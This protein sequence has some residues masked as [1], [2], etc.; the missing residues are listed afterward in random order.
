[1]VSIRNNPLMAYPNETIYGRIHNTLIRLLYP[2]ADKVIVVSKKIRDILSNQYNIPREKIEVIYNPHNIQ[3]YLKLSEEPIEDEYREIFKDS[4]VFIN[5]GRLMEP[6]GQW[7]LIRAF[8]KVVEAHSNAKLIILG[9]GKLRKGLEDLIRKLN[10]GNKVF[11]IGVHKNPFKFL[12]N[13]QCYVHSSLWEGLP[14]TLIEALTLNLPIISTDCETGPRE[15]LT[16]ELDID[17]KIDYPYF[18]KYGIL[19]KPFPRKYIFK[20]LEEKPLIEQE[21][22]LAELMI[23]MIENEELR[24][25]YSNGLERAR[26]FD[27]EK[28]I[29]KWEEVIR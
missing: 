3:N 14:N 11:L 22:Q 13:S 15:I 20:D 4:F 21:K 25:R 28:I 29:R 24:K 19:I 12:K 16:P 6:K 1:M 10:L 7:F 9:E 26:D 23:R 2:K 5:I 27:I 18:G 17:K 8:K